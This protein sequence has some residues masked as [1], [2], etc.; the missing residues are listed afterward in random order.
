MEASQ[1]GVGTVIAGILGGVGIFLVGMILLS[2]GLQAAAGDALRRILQRFVRRPLS[3]LLSGTA[4]TAL[5]QSS[6]ATTLTTIGF[7]SAGLLTFPQAVGLV[8][9]ANLGTTS[10]GWIVALLGLKFSVSVVALPMVGVGALLRLLG[11]GRS[12]HLGLALAGFG[13]IFVGI[14]VLQGTMEGLAGRMDPARFPGATLA[15]RI[16]LLLLGVAMTVVLQSSSAAVAMTL[17]ALHAGHL[18]LDQ[19]AYLVIGQNVGTTVKAGLAAIGASIPARRTAVAHIL[20]NLGSGALAILALPL[21]L[22]ASAA[23]AGEG[24]PATAIAIFHTSF[25]VLGLLVFFPMVGPFSR[26]VERLVPERVPSLTRYLDRSVAAIPSVAV[27]AARRA[28]SAVAGALFRLALTTSPLGDVR[29][30]D[31]PREALARIR[32]F[33]GNV[34]SSPDEPA[35]HRR[36]LSVLHATDHLERFAFLLA[37]DRTI[38]ARAAREAEGGWMEERD[39]LRRAFRH[40]TQVHGD[41]PFDGSPPPGEA[42]QEELEPVFEEVSRAMA[43][44]RRRHREALFQK[45]AAGSVHPGEAWVALD[46]LKGMD[47][48]GY[49]AWRAVHHLEQAASDGGERNGGERR[50]DPAGAGAHAPED[51]DPMGR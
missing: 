11:R 10:T 50:E 38:L 37:G 44:A 29:S 15:G 23:L 41:P 35:V 27:E 46:R 13:L 7:V 25:N 51:G 4:V 32:E 36:H 28:A 31:E 22:P 20:F 6:S 12:R 8:F 19:T 24:D 43:E 33:M 48:L 3:A 49:H 17:T 26:W 1:I 47:T 30:L 18:S 5:V 40:W 45:A 2:E 16:A 42:P 9:G 39:E 21:L 14:D 34:R